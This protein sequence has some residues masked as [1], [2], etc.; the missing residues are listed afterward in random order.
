VWKKIPNKYVDQYNNCRLCSEVAKA[1]LILVFSFEGGEM[2]TL[3]FEN[4]HS[5]SVTLILDKF[6]KII[7]NMSI[8]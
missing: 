6:N 1:Y 3:Y 8:R 5:F 4:V 2:F 7:L